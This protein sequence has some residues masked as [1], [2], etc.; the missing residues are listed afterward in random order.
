MSAE[1]NRPR[2]IHDLAAWKREGRKLAMLTC[3]DALYARILEAAG[4]D[5]LLVGDSLHQVL[6]GHETTLGA[7]LDAMIYHAAAVRRG[8]RETLVFIDLPFLTYQVSIADAIRNAGRAMQEA[9]V[10]GVKLEGG[11]PMAPTIR[12]LTEIGIPVV[13]H[14]G[15]T[16]QSVHQ[17]GG[18]KVQGRDAAAADRLLADAKGVEEAGACALVLELVPTALAKK[19]TAA[20]SIP[21]IGIGAGPHCDGQVL[22]LHDMLG[23]NEGFDPKF[24]KKYGALAG[25]TKE[26]VAKYVQEVRGGAYPDAAHSFD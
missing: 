12:A 17:L 6:G 21:T 5:L 20:V 25:A 13:A 11:R 15:L 14:L 10:D 7:T 26:A 16:P 3:Y 24:L 8:A 4:V 2:T 19:V 9:E 1:K 22:V 23:L 18:Y